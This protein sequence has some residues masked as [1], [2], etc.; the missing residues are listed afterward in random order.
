[1]QEEP[2]QSVVLQTLLDELFSKVAQQ[3]QQHP[4]SGSSK[5]SSQHVCVSSSG[6]K[7]TPAQ[8]AAH[9]TPVRLQRSS[10]SD[11]SAAAAAAQQAAEK[12][13]ALNAD[14]SNA[15]GY[16]MASQVGLGCLL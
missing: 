16:G 10:G 1:V 11:T 12:A 13:A 9:P 4:D 6:I 3:Q 15:Q 2:Q 8:V 7:I 5:S 14:S